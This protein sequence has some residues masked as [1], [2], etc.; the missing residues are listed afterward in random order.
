MKKR[1]VI[2]AACLLF[3]FNLSAQNLPVKITF[4]ITDSKAKKISVAGS[5]NNWNPETNPLTKKDSIWKTD[6]YLDPGYYYYKLVVDSN[7]IPDPS[8]D[9]QI[10]DGGNSF[11]SIIKAG[12]P[13][14]PKRKTAAIKLP[15]QYLPEPI[16][17]NNP[18]WIELYY[19][20]W[21]MAWN[22]IARGNAKNGF[23]KFY[24]D[25][26]F[27]EL[28]YQWDSN[29][30]AAFGIYANDLFPAIQ[31][32][33][34]FYNKQR[35]DGYIQRVYWEST[36]KIANEP[37]ED[38]PMVNP[39]LFAWIELR[40]Y[41]LTGDKN[42]LRI[43]LPV[44]VKYYSWIE[45]NMRT[46]WGNGLYYNTPLGSGMD[47]T[48]R[49]G[50]DKGGYIDMSAQQALAAKCISEIAE[51][52]NKDLVQK[53]FH[54]KYESLK[55]TINYNC[56]NDET[57]FYYDFKQDGSLSSTKHIG[58]FWTL[59]SEVADENKF[60][61]LKKHLTNPAEFWRPHLVPTLSGDDP[62]FDDRGHYWLGSVWAPTNFMV[63]KGLEEYGDYNLAYQIA[64]NHI[65]NISEVYYNFKPE[66]NN[67]A[68][69][70]RYADDYKTI[71][72][73]YS[74]EYKIPATRWDNTFYSRQD[75]VGWSG[76]GP[77]AMLIENIIGINIDV[78]NNEIIWR[79]N[80]ADKHGIKNLNFGDQ[81]IDLICSPQNDVYEFSINSKTKF[82]LGIFI[83]DQKF[84]KEINPGVNIFQVKF[85]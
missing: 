48:P 59:T 29:F 65:K 7:W 54:D 74:S 13:P 33:D 75:F 20:A 85:R 32:L 76:L 80:R 58:A 3:Y 31:S 44:L 35:D 62:R 57:K 23:V 27:N 39:P 52:I 4:K 14:I 1:S 78:P 10:N 22:K 19:T 64:E 66:E 11:N 77:I 70:E 53:T 8:N 34:N 42:R 36:G 9:W 12:E 15:K 61:E 67:I 26:G 25:E 60:Q 71:W 24:M 40:N 18:E 50:V 37:T 43:V 49:E 30:M 56:W 41:K 72:E 2:F 82:S 45:K 21:E 16:L 81:K 47:N 51:I 55:L 69:E 46:K 17:E 6:I 5:F 68:F 28:V 73:C 63:V 83:N 79:I 84:V 38:E